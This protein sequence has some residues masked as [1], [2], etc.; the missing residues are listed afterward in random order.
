MI[1]LTTCKDIYGDLIP[2]DVATN[3]NPFYALSSLID[4]GANAELRKILVTN[5]DSLTIDYLL[6]RY[7]KIMSPLFMR[8]YEI[9]EEDLGAMATAISKII[10]MKFV[11]NWN[12]L[13]EA[14]FGDYNPIENYNMVE[15]KETDYE[16]K[17]E[18]DISESTTNSYNGFNA[19][20]MKD[21]SK[22]V[23]D[24]D[25]TVTKTDTGTK[26][27]NELTRHGNI[28]VTT[29]QQMIESSYKLAQKNI[30]D[31][32]YRDIDSILFID[33]YN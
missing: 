30:I 5:Y 21:V 13:A 3:K 17:T 28:G 24:A 31:I 11:F 4:S 9:H 12:K 7:D 10:N 8:L 20:E 2:N 6:S 19:D 29:S 26:T 14:T 32:I 18:S 25:N 1:E 16:E 15:N 23:L 33:Y 27:K 22:S